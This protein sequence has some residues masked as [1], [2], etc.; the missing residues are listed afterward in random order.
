MEQKVSEESRFKTAG[1]NRPVP[2]SIRQLR[3]Q[4]EGMLRDL[5][6][7]VRLLDQA[8]EAELESESIK[9]PSHFA[10]PLS[11]RVLIARRDNLKATIA[12]L[13]GA[14]TDGPPPIQTPA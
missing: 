8:I 14:F 9:D 11:A 6:G 3:Q 2:N 13:S 5:E 7:L 10:I 4:T 1:P 12:T